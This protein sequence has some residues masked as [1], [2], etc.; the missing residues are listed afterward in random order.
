M[1]LTNLFGT[2]ILL[3]VSSLALAAPDRV[4]PFKHKAIPGGIAIVATGIAVNSSGSNIPK[5]MLGK[6][7]VAVMEEDG[8]WFAIVGISLATEPGTHELVISHGRSQSTV[9][10]LVDAHPYKEQR[11][12]IKD[13]RKVNPTPL[14]MERINK[15]N[16]RI[17]EVKAY[18]Y[19]KL[20]SGTLNMPVEGILTS[21]FGLKRFFND[22]PRRPHGGIDI[23]GPTGTP[24]VAPATGLV[25]D[26]GD[27]FFNGPSDWTSFTLVGWV[28]RNLD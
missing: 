14:D 3:C 28:K 4:G 10:F 13:K 25:V 16:V 2:L 21:P 27:Y 12:V 5:A 26:T 6:R 17:G 20:L 22:Q 9:S 11:I 23:A 7:E 8:Q 18:R 15:E 24:I 1:R 19:K